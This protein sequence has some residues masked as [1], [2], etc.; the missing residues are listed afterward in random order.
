MKS[1]VHGRKKREESSEGRDSDNADGAQE[2][3]AVGIHLCNGDRGAD[4]GGSSHADSGS[5]HAYGDRHANGG[6][7]DGAPKATADAPCVPPLT[8]AGTDL[9]VISPPC[10]LEGPVGFPAAT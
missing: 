10:T 5:S 8:A 3:R 2:A 4:G 7:G 1:K 6:N 9:A